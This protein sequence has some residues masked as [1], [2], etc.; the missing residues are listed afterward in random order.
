M[1]GLIYICLLNQGP[2][3]AFNWAMGSFVFVTVGIWSITSQLLK[4]MTKFVSREI[5]RRRIRN[6][7]KRIQVVVDSLPRVR[8]K[9]PE[10]LEKDL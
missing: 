8:R 6:E 7:H 9:R 5:C 1:A 2:W 4:R 3:V 10:E